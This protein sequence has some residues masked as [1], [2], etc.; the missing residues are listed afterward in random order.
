MGC[1]YIL[2]ASPALHKLDREEEVDNIKL[3]SG[4]PGLDDEQPRVTCIIDAT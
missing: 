3:K 1:E 4:H 2:D